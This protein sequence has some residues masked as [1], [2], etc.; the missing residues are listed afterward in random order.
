ML[1]SAG[2]RMQGGRVPMPEFIRMLSMVLGRTV[3]DGTGLTGL[4]DLQLDFLPDESTEVL[5]APPPGA[6]LDSKTPSIF[7]ALQE[8]LGLRLEATKGPVE[9]LVIDG[10]ERPSAN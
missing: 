8:Q 4:F 9:V 3:R 6:G 2:A 1:G 5:P 10:V 7:V